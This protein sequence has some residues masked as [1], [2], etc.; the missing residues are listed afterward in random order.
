MSQREYM[1]SYNNKN[2]ESCLYDIADYLER[3]AD[4]LENKK[5]T[6]Q[7]IDK[8]EIANPNNSV[9]VYEYKKVKNVYLLTY[10]ETH[11]DYNQSITV[12]KKSITVTEEDFKE[13][14][15]VLE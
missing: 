8:I 5:V 14:Y 2:L 3:I 13:N 4:S 9:R 1:T 11:E 12:T 6:K 7:C 10:S 15:E